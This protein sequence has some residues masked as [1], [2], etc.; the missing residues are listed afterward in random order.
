MWSKLRGLHILSWDRAIQFYILNACKWS[1]S[2]KKWLK[3]LD[4]SLR[5]FIIICFALSLRKRV[6]SLYVESN[7]IFE[8]FLQLLQ[9]CLYT[10][11]VNCAK[12]KN[13]QKYKW[14]YQGTLLPVL[15]DC[16]SFCKSFE[17]NSYILLSL[18]ILCKQFYVS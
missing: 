4:F 7:G 8:N 11:K 1:V 12:Q 17:I 13:I 2:R 6:A 10:N 5:S 15:Y 14:K 9:I 18:T 16:I 3:M